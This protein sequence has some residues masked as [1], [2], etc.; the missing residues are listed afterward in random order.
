MTPK[1]IRAFD[2]VKK[3]R[4]AELDTEALVL[5]DILK[6]KSVIEG[7]KSNAIG[8]LERDQGSIA[9]EQLKYVGLF[10]QSIFNQVDDMNSQISSLD[11]QAKRQM[12]I[13]T[14]RFTNL[15]AVDIFLDKMKNEAKN[16]YEKKSQK[17]F[18]EIAYL[19][20]HSK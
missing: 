8:L 16:E 17:E 15:R 9:P 5:A 4:K 20:F 19:R 11:N 13:V 2:A 12:S 7:E 1:K 3:I 10:V 6:S 14:K 18:D